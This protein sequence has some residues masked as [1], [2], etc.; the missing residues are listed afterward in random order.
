MIEIKG[1]YNSAK[2]LVDDYSKLEEACYKQILN[3][4]NQKFS[5]DSNI[6]IMPDTHAGAGCVIGF[7]Q[8]ITDKIVPNLV[9]VDIGCGMLVFKIKKEA[10]EKIFNNEELAKLDNVIR[11][12]IPVGMKH[13]N[14]K[15][16]FCS[17]V[18]IN[19]IKPPIKVEELLFSIGSLGGGNH[20]IEVDKD[21]NGDFYIVIHS[22]SRHLGIEVCKYY[23]NKAINFHK[24]NFEEQNKLIAKLKAEGREKDIQTE[25]SKIKKESIPNE[26]AYLVGDDL[27]DYLHDMELSQEYAVWNREAMLDEIIIGMGITKDMI[28]DKFCTIHNYVD[29]KNRILR[30]GAISLQKDEVA[31]IPINM[32]YGSL[33][34]KGK[35]NAEYNYSG[36][37]G[38]GRLMS[39][40]AAKESLSM[41]DF[42]DSMKDVFTTSVCRETIDEAPMAYKPADEILSNIK[43][44]CDVINIIKPIYNLKAAE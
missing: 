14:T 20:F 31:I 43:D 1:K 34:V 15:H 18:R 3:L 26:L 16:N 36:P 38:A 10:G 21:T 27:E 29:V 44:L 28:L 2:V 42:K 32:S 7:T 19:E 9:G 35:G 33:I 11:A 23:Q 41:E 12:N 24:N 25:L 17:R 39:R 40:S 4:L 8:T 13:R 5:E 6:A 37:H 30:K 22:G